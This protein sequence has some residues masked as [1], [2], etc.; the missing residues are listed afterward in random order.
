MI[1][2]LVKQTGLKSGS[3]GKTARQV[4]DQALQVTRAAQQGALTYTIA[5]HGGDIRAKYFGPKETQKGVTIT[6]RGQRVLIAGAFTRGGRFPDRVGLSMG[7]Q[8]FKRAGRGRLGLVVQKSG[9][10]IPAEMVTGAT[11]DAF[12]EVVERDLPDRLAHELMRIL[13]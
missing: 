13:G 8:V 5:S 4:M 1:R 11:A 2:A 3:G 10:T 9:V 12:H 6:P 7:G